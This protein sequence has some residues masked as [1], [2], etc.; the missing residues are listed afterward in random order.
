MS[1]YYW[2]ASNNSSYLNGRRS[3]KTLR[4]A[5]IAGRRYVAEELYGEG[6]LTI[7]DAAGDL[8][9]E[10]ERSIFSAYRWITTATAD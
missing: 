1:T 2:T 9:R 4:G 6:R 10:D 7:T 5:V 8:I 3:A